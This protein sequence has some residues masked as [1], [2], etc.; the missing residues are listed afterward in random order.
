MIGKTVLILTILWAGVAS[1]VEEKPLLR[2][3]DIHGD[4]VVFVY[5]ED[6][7]SAPV[8]G[9]IAQRLTIHDGQER[10]P[11][12]SPDGNWIAFTAQYDGNQD[13]YVMG[14]HGGDIQR[15]TYHPA[16]DDVVGWHPLSGKI[17]FRSS[18]R[19]YS[20]FER[21]YLIAPDGTGLEELPLHEAAAGSYSPDAKQIAYNRVGREDRT[22]KRY[23][24][25]LAQD[26]WLYDFATQKDQQLTEFDGTDRT[27]MWIGDRVYFSSDRSRQL[28]LF[29]I[30]PAD[31]KVQQH[32][33]HDRYDV[34]RPS[35]GGER[36][37]YEMGG[38]IWVLDVA[39]GETRAIPIKIE[40]DSPE[41]RSYIKD[42]SGDITQVAC[43]PSGK[44]ALI[45][46]RG[47]IFTVPR[48]H[49]PSRNLTRSSGAREKDA[50]WSPDGTRIAYISDTSGECEIYI[51]DPLGRDEP[52]RLTTHTS[53]YRHSLKWSPDG[54]K[55]AFADQ[56]LRCY[57]VDI[58]TKQVVEV[59]RSPV[60]PVDVGIDLKPIHD[61]VWSPDSR[62]LAY[63][64]IDADQVSR[65]YIY[66]LEEK[67]IHRVSGDLFND[68]EPVFSA[69]GKHL[70]FI[71]NRRF[72]PTYCDF[73]WEMVYKK[74]AGIYAV[75]LQRDGESVLP[76]RSDEENAAEADAADKQS[77]QQEAEGDQK[78]GNVTV[79]DF[80]GLADRTEALPVPRGNY[81]QL[82]ANQDRLFF[83]NADSGDFNRFEFRAVPS[84]DLNAFSFRDR[85]VETVLEG[86]QT[87]DL[88]SD[89]A[90]IAYRKGS[91]VGIIDAK[92]K[93]SN[94]D[95]VSLKGLKMHYDPVAEWQQIFHEAWRIERD[96]YYDPNMHGIDWE[97]VKQKY[98]CFV[99]HASCRQDLRFI[100]G[101]MIG[102][103][104]TS[105]T[106]VYGGDQRRKTESV[107]VGMLGAD[108]TLDSAAGR[109]RIEK[110]YGVADWTR[111]VIPPLRKPGL[112]I[113]PGTYLLQV[114]G[115]DVTTDKNL[116]SYFQDLAGEQV[117]LLI[118]TTP[119][120]GGAREVTVVP[121]RSERTL[122]YRDWVER[123]R[124]LVAKKTNGL[125][126][127]LHMP[128]TFNGTAREFP[129]YF[130][131]QTQKKGLI[132]DGRFNGGG[133]D[134]DIF[135][136]RLDKRLLAYWTRRYSIDQTTPHI[137]TRAH[138]A[139]L[140]N[141][142]AGSG[143]DM[144][145]MEFQQRKMG[146]VIGTRTWGGLVGVSMSVTL[147][148][149]GRLTAPDY[150]IYSPEGK[151]V[152]ENT[153]VDPD[154][155]VDLSPAE[156]ERGFDAQLERGIQEVMKMIEQDPRN[157]PDH[158][159]FPE[160]GP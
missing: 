113:Q 69:D 24:G 103:L 60:E 110:I 78:N 141:R 157:K 112:N 127:Y 1:A 130:Y 83:L 54:R 99:P 149:G 107:S 106:Y 137:V 13:V 153:G 117:R 138:M 158:P 22:W 93:D 160:D 96:F 156:M 26:I 134:P 34:R 146:P 124:A 28:N 128:D 125:V 88:S 86:I 102:E 152:V 38:E 25:G 20:R 122:R 148:D 41:R 94:G 42:V 47:E 18:R 81:R 145:P 109:Y 19:A 5:G 80:E 79:I 29:S 108:W 16:A 57:Y 67:E 65:I 119:A 142:Q 17:L 35:M 90:H 133:L 62:F 2:F 126:G 105:H 144:L 9:G 140:T 55:I 150:R 56:T 40:T 14:L 115:T 89:G 58:E 50:V 85:K 3:P 143:G 39:T 59:D 123:N 63:S 74:V 77:A 84:M 87:Y 139:L 155:V 45:V 10:F 118:N 159:P 135:L 116:Y 100:I 46:A 66:C 61:F 37:V 82:A 43:S 131:S 154:I 8:S 4:T 136:Q 51:M 21:L 151:W 7:W 111:D 30:N 72:S 31:G 68:F 75:A 114:N 12:F 92:A 95:S 129:K 32:T 104:N 48:E 53:G 120:Q 121:I 11:R 76:L 97:D 6:I 52:I 147:V 101:E 27:P 49:G 36:I 91:Q 132:I 15:V 33:F 98:S 23:R 70:F 73:E 64:R 44:R 71:S